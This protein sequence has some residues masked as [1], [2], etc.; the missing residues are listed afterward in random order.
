MTKEFTNEELEI[1][2]NHEDLFCRAAA[3]DQGYKLDI[4]IN[5]EH[6]IV[7]IAAKEKLESIANGEE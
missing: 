1:M 3:A 4:L 6:W 7:R 2:L 5:D